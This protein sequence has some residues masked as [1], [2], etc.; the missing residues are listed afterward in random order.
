MERQLLIATVL[1]PT[2]G[3][4]LISFSIY[5]L[6]PCILFFIDGIFSIY[7][8]NLR[9]N[10]TKKEV[11]DVFAKNFGS[12]KEQGV[13]LLRDRYLWHGFVE[14]ESYSYV[15]AAVEAKKVL[16]GK[17]PVFIE[18]LTKVTHGK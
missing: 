13:E 2:S 1:E 9:P 8:R 16:I 7:I 17:R 6:V 10:I 12:V 15:Q 14:F 11:K 18:H 4:L 5:S 3:H